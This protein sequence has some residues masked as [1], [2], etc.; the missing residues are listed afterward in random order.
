MCNKNNEVNKIDEIGVKIG[1]PVGTG[2][3]LAGPGRA[4][5]DQKWPL[6]VGRS[7]KFDV[8]KFITTDKK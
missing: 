6:G 1:G 7:E 8:I 4:G 3:T 2:E 5:M